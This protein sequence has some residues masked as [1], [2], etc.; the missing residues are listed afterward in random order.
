VKTAGIEAESAPVRL[1]PGTVDRHR[2]PP[3]ALRLGFSAGLAATE[4]AHIS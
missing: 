2:T 4:K 1:P 3:L